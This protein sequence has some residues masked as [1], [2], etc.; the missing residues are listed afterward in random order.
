[1]AVSRTASF[2]SPSRLARLEVG[3]PNS[4]AS[5]GTPEAARE[6]QIALEGP[7]VE[8][9]RRRRRILRRQCFRIVTKALTAMNCACL[10]YYHFHHKVWIK[11]RGWIPRN[12]STD[13]VARIAEMMEVSVSTQQDCSRL[14]SFPEDGSP[15]NLQLVWM[16]TSVQAF[17]ERHT[18][19][20][21][22]KQQKVAALH[23]I[24]SSLKAL[25]VRWCQCHPSLEYSLSFLYH[26]VLHIHSVSSTHYPLHTRRR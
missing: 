24:D 14:A 6:K 25:Q 15:S 7:V 10:G 3:S 16:L 4:V 21:L 9:A 17:E 13:L 26:C 20:V 8:E 5:P 23:I 12:N 19:A 1:M 11:D 2:E 22:Q 18:F